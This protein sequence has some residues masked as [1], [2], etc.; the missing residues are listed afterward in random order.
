LIYDLEQIRSFDTL[1][2]WEDSLIGSANYAQMLLGLTGTYSQNISCTATVP[3]SLNINFG[4]GFIIQLAPVDATAYGPLPANT[5]QV[6]QLGYNQITT[7]LVNTGDIPVGDAKWAL[8]SVGFKQIDAIRAGDPNGGI[9]PYIDINNPT[10]PFFGPNNSGVPQ[11]TVRQGIADIQL[12]YGAIAPGGSEVPPAAPPGYVGLFLIDLVH[13]QT[14]ITNTDILVAG[15]DAYAGY[16]QAPI[17]A[18]LLNSHHSGATGQAPQIMLSA[19][20]LLIPQEVQGFL[21]T[22]NMVASSGGGAVSCFYSGTGSPNGVH[23][24]NNDVNG[25]SDMYWDNLAKVLYVCDTTGTSTT[26]HWTSVSAT[27]TITSSFTLQI[28]TASGS[29]TPTPGTTFI[30][31]TAV[32][33]GGGGAGGI[34]N[35]SGGNGSG[36]AGGGGGG[37]AIMGIINISL[38]TTPVSVTIGTGGAAAAPGGSGGGGGT[39]YFG[40][41]LFASGGGGGT[42]TSGVSPGSGGGSGSAGAGAG[43]FAIGISGS[44]GG[45]G[46]FSAGGVGGGTAVGGGGRGSGNASFIGGAGGVWGGGGGGGASLNFGGTAATGGAGAQGILI[47]EEFQGP[48]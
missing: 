1:W 41:Y 25:A 29:Y 8:I 26:A 23:A 46:A 18:G 31:A 37:A 7:K 2:A 17:L 35:F 14:T 28:F 5:Q 40:S 10:Q 15:P 39:T 38:L 12:T 27:A 11:N 24:G 36:S 45:S 34:S 20:D 3:P 47:I 42:P 44:C 19:N 9:L 6:M 21:P 30:R 16:P 43:I 4:D 48:A 33:G 32:G 13:G 22:A